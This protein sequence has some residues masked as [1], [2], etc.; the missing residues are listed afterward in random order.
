LLDDRE[1]AASLAA[2]ARCRVT[3]EFPLE[4]AVERHVAL[5]ESLVPLSM[6]TSRP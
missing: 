4:A 3:Q 1:L 2:G 6:D 5:F